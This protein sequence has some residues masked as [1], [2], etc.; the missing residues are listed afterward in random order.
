M[1]ALHLHTGCGRSACRVLGT[2]AQKY[3]RKDA[4][5]LQGIGECG[6]SLVA[7]IPG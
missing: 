1:H 3:V 6:C 2:Y 5:A 4:H 7:L